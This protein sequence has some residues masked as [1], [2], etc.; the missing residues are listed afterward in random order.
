MTEKRHLMPVAVSRQRVER[1]PDIGVHEAAGF[2]DRLQLILPADRNLMF[3][4]PSA[5]NN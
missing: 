3:L 5:A 4:P 2:D 1:H